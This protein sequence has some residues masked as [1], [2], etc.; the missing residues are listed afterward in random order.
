MGRKKTIHVN[1][2]KI[3]SNRKHGTDAPPISIK[4]GRKNIYASSVSILGPS[5]LRYSPHKNILS[6]GARVVLETTA[7]LEA[8][9]K[10]IE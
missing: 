8:D 10:L 4:V 3:R 7:E 6:C 9:G 2:H 5:A 1:I